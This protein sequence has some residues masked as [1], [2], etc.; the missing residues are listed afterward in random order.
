MKKILILVMCSVTEF[1]SRLVESIEH[2]WAKDIIDGKYEN[3]SYYSYSPMDD[4]IKDNTL[5]K[6]IGIVDASC[7]SIVVPCDDEYLSTYRKTMLAFKTIDNIINE[8]D[9]V[10]KVNPYTFVNVALLNSFVQSLSE[11]E[12]RIFCGK[13]MSSANVSSP[14]PYCMYANGSAVMFP[15][16]KYYSVITNK[17]Y[18]N[19][20]PKYESGYKDTS[21]EKYRRCVDDSAIGSIFN[22]YMINMK[23]DH[24]RYYQDWCIFSSS[25]ISDAEL[26][27]YITIDIDSYCICEAINEMN[28]INNLV[29]EENKNGI[30]LTD[31]TSYMNSGKSPVIYRIL[32]D[33][34]GDT[35]IYLYND[36]INWLDNDTDYLNN[37]SVNDSSV[38]GPEII[39]DG[40]Y[41]SFDEYY[42]IAYRELTIE[43]H[44]NHP[45]EYTEGVVDG[46]ASD[47]SSL[48][49]KIDTMDVSVSMLSNSFKWIDINNI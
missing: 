21:W 35:S 16:K 15:V 26:Y 5:H 6:N 7:N 39:K 32:D 45:S 43:T 4:Y 36:F 24:T 27:K 30:D 8:F 25:K 31:I 1:E 49:N 28:R 11:D 14:Y 46:I 33:S 44:Y 29:N 2:T 38:S 20:V 17:I 10:L 48:T 3:I 13:I 40:Y 18:R 47:V 23:K 34:T 12:E 22:T 9:Y 37:S 19:L 41:L 42:N